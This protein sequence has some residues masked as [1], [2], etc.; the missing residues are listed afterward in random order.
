MLVLTYTIFDGNPAQSGPCNWPSH[1]DIPIRAATLENAVA[2]I[3]KQAVRTAQESGEYEDGDRL[4]F[5][6]WDKDG[7]AVHHGR[8]TI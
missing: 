7:I 8:V 2:R 1:T 6:V 5:I 3:E 4:W